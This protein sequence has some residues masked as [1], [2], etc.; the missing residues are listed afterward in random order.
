MCELLIRARDKV[1]D[2]PQLDA[3]CYKRGDVVAVV[4]DGW[5]WGRVELAS[6]EWRILQLPNV[7]VEQAQAFVA[8]EVEDDPAQ[9]SRMLR[10]RGWAFDLEALPAAVRAWL[11]DD[12]RKTPTRR[13]NLTAPQILALRKRKQRLRDPDV[14]G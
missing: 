6:P 4:E 14:I 9:P 8:E 11:A 1:N 10:R 5:Q 3:K 13:V 12:S 7:S 2:D